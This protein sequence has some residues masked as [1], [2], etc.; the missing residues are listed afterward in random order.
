MTDISF[1]DKEFWQK[2]E[3]KPLT[4]KSINST[5]VKLIFDEDPSEATIIRII[6][7]EWLLT[8]I[9]E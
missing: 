7:P 8:S 4:I 3:K 5:T 6:K 9:V 1:A 2:R